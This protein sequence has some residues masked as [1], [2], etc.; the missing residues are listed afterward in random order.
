MAKKHKHASLSDEDQWNLSQ[1]RQRPS[2]IQA[3]SIGSVVRRL[4]SQSGYGQT[5]QHADL[6]DVWSAA[7]GETLAKLTQPGNISRGLL[8]IHAANSTAAQELMFQKPQVLAQLKTE[9]PQLGIR[10]MKI[11]VS[12][13]D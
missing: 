6:K 5:Q 3:K 2:R 10:D 11:R 9:L 8:Q 1:I 13:F 7:V 4:M 12:T